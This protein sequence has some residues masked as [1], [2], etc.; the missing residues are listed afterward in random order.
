[1]QI[2][3]NNNIP[4]SFPLVAIGDNNYCEPMEQ[5][6]TVFNLRHSVFDK[7]EAIPKLTKAMRSDIKDIFSSED[8]SILTKFCA[9]SQFS[10][11]TELFLK[12]IIK[13]NFVYY[14]DAPF[15]KV[16]E[17]LQ[18]PDLKNR[19]TQKTYTTFT[20]WISLANLGTQK[21][22]TI[23]NDKIYMPFP[24]DFND[25]FDCQL[26]LHDN[27]MLTLGD[28]NEQNVP[29]VRYL[30]AMT[31]YSFNVSSFSL[32][33]PLS[34]NSNHMWG[35]YG[36]NGSGFALT[37]E[38]DH[39]IA[40]VFNNLRNNNS[41]EFLF[42]KPVNYIENYNPIQKFK[43]CLDE[44]RYRGKNNIQALSNFFESFAISKTPQWQFEQEL[45]FYKFSSAAY[46]GFISQ[47]GGAVTDKTCIEL[48]EY[49]E[50]S[51]QKVNHEVIFNRP[52]SIVLGWNC[53]IEDENIQK[54]IQY[55]RTHSIK[56]I[57]LD[58]YLNY[59]KNEFY[60]AEL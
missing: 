7:L 60:Y 44:Y 52:T 48:L 53:N 49:I 23:I 40:Q 13:D 37:F 26:H 20:K 8:I 18:R 17:I 42:F 45:R 41:N 21:V 12:K 25:R 1:M 19:N 54:L 16:N 30:H 32:N 59:L 43:F 28:N 24:C 15:E 33:N 55:A 58:K 36:D 11:T 39:L 6:K 2:L 35:L 34:T 50:T 4:T 14:K 46:E 10:T 22:D 9:E 27:E 38:L 51:K 3:V 31:K 56:V 29:L 57:K 47:Y 5:L